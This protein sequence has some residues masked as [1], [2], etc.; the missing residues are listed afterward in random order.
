ME[1]YIVWMQTTVHFSYKQRGLDTGED[2][3]LW[4][5]WAKAD[6][7]EASEAVVLCLQVLQGWSPFA[8]SRTLSRGKPVFL[9][10]NFVWLGYLLSFALSRLAHLK[11]G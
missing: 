1:F 8:P 2:A 4:T 10:I 5:P 11:V 7:P 6:L 3:L 9:A